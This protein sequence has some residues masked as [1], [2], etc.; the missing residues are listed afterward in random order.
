MSTEDP[1]AFLDGFEERLLTPAKPKPKPQSKLSIVGTAEPPVE[2]LRANA[3]RAQ[4]RLYEAE[5][6]V[7]F[8]WRRNFKRYGR[9]RPIPKAERR[10]QDLQDGLDAAMERIRY[11][12][13][14]ERFYRRE[15]DPFRLGLYGPTSDLG[16]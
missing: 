1:L 14:M 12:Q 4:E 10:A 11:A 15:L 2:A 16:D 7:A 3:D 5:K 9:A 8:N 13:M 6:E